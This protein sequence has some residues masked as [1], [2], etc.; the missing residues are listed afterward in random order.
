MEG[1]LQLR[2]PAGWLKA[3][4]LTHQKAANTPSDTSQSSAATEQLAL[5][6]NQG[7]SQRANV[8]LSP[9]IPVS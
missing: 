9:K 4:W 6:E 5:L 3:D 1:P 2:K 8:L 7:S